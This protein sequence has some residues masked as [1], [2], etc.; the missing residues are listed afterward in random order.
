MQEHEDS[1]PGHGAK[2][3]KRLS[4]TLEFGLM[5]LFNKSCTPFGDFKV[6]IFYLVFSLP[7]EEQELTAGKRKQ[8]ILFRDTP[9]HT[10]FLKQA[11]A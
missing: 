1:K 4:S 6:F 7:A 5:M 11:P 8:R 3:G 9:L 10:S 2:A